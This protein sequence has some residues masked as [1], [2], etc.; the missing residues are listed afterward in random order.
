[1][2][3]RTLRTTREPRWSRPTGNSRSSGRL[4]RTAR[5]RSRRADDQQEP[6][7][8]GAGQLG[9]RGAC[10]ERPGDRRVDLAVGDPGRQLALGLP[11]LPQGLADPV[12]VAV[13]QPVDGETGQVAE[14]V[15]LR[16]GGF[17]V[18]G[19][20]GQDRG[21][22]AGDA[23][24]EEHDLLL[25]GPALGGGQ[26]EVGGHDLL[27]G[28]EADVADPAE[29]GDVLVLLADGLPAPL[30]L[31]LAGPLGQFLGGHLPP[32]VGEQGVQQADGYR[33]GGP[34]PGPGGRDV[35]QRGDLDPAASPRSSASPRGPARA[36]GHQP[37]TR[38]PSASS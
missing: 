23:G 2:S 13:G 38:S 10:V 24:I 20:L 18:R 35:G 32:A 12:H 4:S 34:E 15:Q 3:R 36:P 9:A 31:D 33:R 25:Q 29:G 37:G 16:L 8:A 17:D 6:A 11:A 30:D 7:T 28:P 19:L 14:P 1:M 27:P 21:R 22:A 5:C 26:S